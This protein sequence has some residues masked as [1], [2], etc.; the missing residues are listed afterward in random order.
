MSTLEANPPVI[1]QCRIIHA[2][3]AEVYRAWIDPEIVKKWFGPPNMLVSC[4]NFDTRIGGAYRIELSPRTEPS[5]S[6][7]TADQPPLEV[8][9]VYT[10]V[11][12]DELLQFTWLAPWAPG[13]ESL[14]TITFRDTPDGTEISVRHDQLLSD[15]SRDGHSNGWAAALDKIAA[16]YEG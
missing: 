3:R 9:G 10:K 14:V 8:S 16:I 1:E 15:A 7:V 12:P 2:T 13:E 4:A 11:V 6:E 5:N